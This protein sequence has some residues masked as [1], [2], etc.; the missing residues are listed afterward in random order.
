MRI[1]KLTLFISVLMVLVLVA[2]CG[3]VSTETTTTATTT[4][5]AKT[6]TTTSK[7]TTETTTEA[8]ETSATETEPP[9][10]ESP[11]LLWTFV[12]ESE[13]FAPNSL[14]MHPDGELVT[15]G[16]Y[17]A[18]YTHRLYDSELTDVDTDYTHSVDSL[19]ISS[20]GQYLAAG[21]AV[22]GAWVKDWTGEA[23]PV[24]LHRGNNTF[25]AFDPNN[26]LLATGNRDGVI[27]LWSMPDEQLAELSYGGKDYLWG[28][29][30]H[31][32]GEQVASLQWTDEGLINIWSIPD[33]AIMKTMETNIL[34]GSS[35]NVISFSPDGSYFGAYF[36]EDRNDIIRIFDTEQYNLIAEIP[37][38]KRANQITFSPDGQMITVASLY[39][40]TRIWSSTTGELLYTLDQSLDESVTTGGSKALAFTPDGGHL[41]VIRNYGDL[42]LWRLPGSEP[43]P[44][45][46]IDIYQ[47]VPIPGDVLFDTGSADLK[48]EADEVLSELAENLFATLSDA[49]LTFVGHTDSRGDASS[50]EQLSLDRATSV[51][52]WFETW[53]SENN[54]DGWTF[55]VDGK[56]ETEL[57]VPD[58]DGEGN[59][60][61][62]AG[63]VNRRVEIEIES[64]G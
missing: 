11:E 33:Q 60:R 17:M 6:T 46:T 40:Q 20:D 47:P 58:V 8:S 2:G 38:E 36:R 7:T 39:E 49:K 64:N 23:E 53:A 42:E 1:G 4:T 51:K 44:E 52:N 34:V 37:L 57:K 22:G 30:V 15:V 32:S 3:S 55:A 59:F 54:A 9:P 25:V 29:T 31:P 26:S 45:P 24:Q 61:E 48:A 35:N 13:D 62:E 56:G 41:A 27:W 5:I 19:S 14:A 50:N 18:T 28:I 16:A 12:Y 43:L 21:L 10:A 63:R